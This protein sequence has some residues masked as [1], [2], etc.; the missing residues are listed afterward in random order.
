MVAL[1]QVGDVAPNLD[2]VKSVKLPGLHGKRMVA[3]LLKLISSL[4]ALPGT[5]A[6]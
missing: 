3:I 2:K 4:F 1:I 6:N 5:P